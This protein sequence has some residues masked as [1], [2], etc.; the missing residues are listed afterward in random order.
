MEKRKKIRGFKKTIG[1]FV[2]ALGLS[3]L[4]LGL[5]QGRSYAKGEKYTIT[6]VRCPDG[7]I[8]QIKEISSSKTFYVDDGTIAIV[9]GYLS[10]NKNEKQYYAYIMDDKG[11]YR[12][13]EIS[14]EYLGDSKKT[15]T[16][17]ELS[18]YDIY[19]IRP[20]KGARIREKETT[21][22]E[23]LGAVGYGD[24]VLAR[25]DEISTSEFDGEWQKVIAIDGEQQVE[26]GYMREDLLKKVKDLSE[27]NFSQEVNE[28]NIKMI[29]DTSGDGGIDLNV[30]SEPGG[31]EIIGGIPNGSVVEVIGEIV[32]VR[33]LDRVEVRYISDKG[34]IIEG[35]VS[36]KYL[37]ELGEV[38]KDNIEKISRND[39]E[40]ISLNAEGTAPGIDVSGT[41]GKQLKKLL[42]RGVPN[43]V[44]TKDYTSGIDISNRAGEIN[45]VYIK[46]GASGYGKGKLNIIK[47]YD[48]YIE[49]IK[50][51]EEKGIPYGFYYYSTAITK[52]EADQEVQH[53]KKVIDEL[54]S[55]YGLK[56]NI[57]PLA[58]DIETKPKNKE[59]QFDASIEQVSK[60]KAHWINKAQKLGISQ[61]INVYIS[62]RAFYPESGERII[63]I[64]VFKNALNNPEKVSIWLGSSMT[65]K[66]K[67]PKNL[68]KYIEYL[69]KYG[70]EVVARQ[71][72]LDVDGGYDINIYDANEL[73]ELI[74]ENNLGTLRGNNWSVESNISDCFTNESTSSGYEDWEYDL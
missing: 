48:N 7:T 38:S 26:T 15:I 68:D 6:N 27:V 71:I 43:K 49:Q 2:V 54:K 17:S 66:G 21:S 59:R 37:R 72:V 31:P 42:E 74:D 30:R 58:L 57:L 61:K 35:W 11:V 56:Y 28:G 10:G 69:N 33:G 20:E 40:D 19:Q 24:Y 55:K 12:E 53:I 73:Q 70:F 4:I 45:F 50:V 29:V 3:A 63:D 62:K 64:E 13:G 44:T 34:N 14:G 8:A 41:S 39:L 23:I 46:L 25:D 22:S 32:T 47:S 51:C 60:A 5:V 18:K 1:K 16:G 36:A 9:Q 52:D 65:S 67:D